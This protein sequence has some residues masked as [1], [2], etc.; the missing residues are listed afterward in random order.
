MTELLLDMGRRNNLINFK[1]Q[2]AATAEVL[3][4]CAGEFFD[5][6]VGGRE[7][8]FFDETSVA[9]LVSA[10]RETAENGG[11]SGGENGE[12]GGENSG[13]IAP[14]TAPNSNLNQTNTA[15][16]PKSARENAAKTTANGDKTALKSTPKTPAPKGKSAPKTIAKERFLQLCQAHV[17]RGR[18]LAFNAHTSAENVAKTLA[19]KSKEYTQ[20]AGINVLYAAFGFLRYRE[21]AGAIN[22]QWAQWGANSN[23]TTQR[24]GEINVNSAQNSAQ[25]LQNPAANSATNPAQNA[26]QTTPQKTPQTAAANSATNQ[27]PTPP[28]T[29]NKTAPNSNL[30]PLSP[31][32]AKSSAKS[33]AKPRQTPCANELAAPLLLVGVELKREN[34]LKPFKLAALDDEIVLNPALAHKLAA[35]FGIALPAYNGEGLAQWL[36]HIAQLLAPLGF[37][38]V[39]ECKLGVFSFQKV[40]MYM[41]LKQNADDALANGNIRALLGGFD[42]GGFGAGDDGAGS[43]GAGAGNDGAGADGKSPASSPLLALHNVVDADSTQIEAILM[44]KSGRSFVLQGPPGTGK[45]Q[46]I[47]NI[48]AE[49]LAQGKRVLFVSEKQ[50]A[51][52]VVYEKLRRVQLGE[53]CLQLHSHKANKKEF[54]KELAAALNAPR[55]ELNDKAARELQA[56]SQALARL[57]DYARELHANRAALG[58]SLF[59]L[60]G[61]FGALA[62]VADVAFGGD[63]TRVGGAAGANGAGGGAAGANGAGG[64]AAGAINS[65]LGGRGALNS[66][67]D[68]A[69]TATTATTTGAAGATG[70]NSATAANSANSANSTPAAAEFLRHVCEL[71]SQCADFTAS[72]GYNYRQNTWFG[73]ALQDLSFQKKSQLKDD[74]RAVLDF[75]KMACEFEGVAQNEL[76]AMPANAAQIRIWRELA[77][78][79]ALVRPSLFALDA[80]EISRALRQDFGGFFS[81]LF[82]SK[83]RKII[84]DLSA[85]VKGAD[86]KLGYDEAVKLA[87][88]LAYFATNFAA[89]DAFAAHF[90]PKFEFDDFVVKTREFFAAFAASEGALVRVAECFDAGAFDVLAAGFSTLAARCENALENFDQLAQYCQ[91]RAVLTALREAGVAEFL[92]AA[93]AANVPPEQFSSAFKKAFAHQWIDKIINETPTLAAFNRISQ[94]KTVA[95]F[96]QKDKLHFEINKAKIRAKLF[97]LRPNTQFISKGSPEAVLL[98]EAEKKRN[99]KPVRELF[100]ALGGLIFALKPCVLMSPLS[101]STF[102][103]DDNGLFDAVIFDEASQIF[104]QDALNSLYR[105]RQCIVVGDSKQMPPSNFFGASVNDDEQ[106]DDDSGDVADFE[107][108]LDLS[109]GSFAQLRLKWHYRSRYEQLIAFSNK[110]FYDNSLVTFPSPAVD[111]RGVGVDFVFAGGTFDRTSKTNLAE[112]QRIVELVFEHIATHPE[113][114]LGVVAF[115]QA[116]QNLIEKLIDNRRESSPRT[117]HFFAEGA[118]EDAETFFVKN[119]E[120]VQGDERDTIIF[121]VAYGFDESG[122]FLHNFGP[123]N[124]EGG[125]RRLNV[126]VTRAKSNVILVASIRHTDIDLSRTDSV[127][128]RLLREYIDFAQNG[129]IALRRSLNVSGFESP[130]SAFEVEV[131]EFLRARGFA[132]D[133]QVGCAGFRIDLAVKRAAGSDYVL[134]VECDGASY[135]SGKNARD[136]DRLRQEILERMGWRFYRVWSTEWYYNKSSEQKRLLAAVSAAL[137]DGDGG[138]G[139]AGAGASG[140]NSNLSGENANENG[141]EV[142]SNS[143]LGGNFDEVADET[144]PNSILTQNHGAT[145]KTPAPAATFA[146]YE[147]AQGE[148][149][150]SQ[151]AGFAAYACVDLMDLK[152]VLA[153][154]GL[155]DNLRSLL[156]IAVF[157]ESPLCEEWFLRRCFGRVGASE[158]RL[159]ALA[160][161]ASEHIE[162]RDG[163]LFWRGRAVA[164][165]RHDANAAEGSRWLELGGDGEWRVVCAGQGGGADFDGGFDSAGGS[166]GGF[167]DFGAGGALRVRLEGERREL[168]DIAPCELAAGIAEL[169]RRGASERDWIFNFMARECG[170][171]RTGAAIKRR[172]QEALNAVK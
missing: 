36:A 65:N 96:A 105:A 75:A 113:R 116:Q 71:L 136:R 3:L 58:R 16:A 72:I 18:L 139:G 69:T 85:G 66:N 42:E 74:L 103:P 163:F 62:E 41:D 143:N 166:G 147:L 55:T 76:G 56:K 68:A 67:L 151:G 1:D 117:E 20:E 39:S 19:K 155:N 25:I 29:F 8:E 47:T 11:E 32:P 89:F 70:A 104:P 95:Q 50:A 171:G 24:G 86:G 61:E 119:L 40:S 91:F 37:E 12:N 129:D 157:V 164:F 153:D 60:Y 82:S 121:S 158:R 52:N 17:K 144:A 124:R 146:D 97:S 170:F 98:R 54:I 22:A 49:L 125:E 48:I 90:A 168:K 5:A 106:G 149:H 77:E 169:K 10:R 133:L 142:A 38:V 123:L 2:K 145:A 111:K 134:A 81:R 15:T 100:S 34:S 161:G 110:N 14:S 27:P 114:T 59:E 46:T 7:F 140:A 138:A 83:Y 35:E 73:L 120:T 84:A 118:G 109:C 64:G 87:A 93:I 107:S 23:L 122:K 44:A 94:D 108:V 4:P 156:E 167:G 115:S 26:P 150:A 101:V 30:P 102:L 33:S 137:A 13:E 172:L 80:R 43:T 135:H 165:R 154:A 57:D 31:A 51:L 9:G 131:A 112:A 160:A 6:L 99:Q 53:F 21:N 45:S 130:G 126:A 152:C 159:L 127:G 162:R 128:A 78:F 79:C 28:A 148:L 132:V 92:D 63:L 88:K 141:V